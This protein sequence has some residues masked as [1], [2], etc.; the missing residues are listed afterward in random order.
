M[1]LA[2]SREGGT[3][4]FVNCSEAKAA[5]VGNIRAGD[6]RYGLHLDR[7]EDGIGCEWN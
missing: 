6:P 2:G 4:P 1:P 5:G 3:R 7:D